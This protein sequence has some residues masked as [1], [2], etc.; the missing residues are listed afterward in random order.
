MMT[1]LF[2]TYIGIDYSGAGRPEGRLQGIQCIWRGGRSS[3]TRGG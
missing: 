3:G 2:D 1:P